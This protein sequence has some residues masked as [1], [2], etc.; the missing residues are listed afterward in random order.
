M[1][2]VEAFKLIK[3]E[4]PEYKL[5]IVGELSWFYEVLMKK[6]ERLK[7]QKDIIFTG[8]LED[9]T[10]CCFYQN[11]SIFVFP[12]LYEGFGIP[13]LEAMAC[14]TPVVASNVCSL[15][16]VVK[17]NGILVNPYDVE[18]IANG[19]YKVLKDNNL[20]QKLIKKGLCYVKDFS[21][22]KSAQKHIEVYEKVGKKQ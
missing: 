9:Q 10:L 21:W 11:A 14:G 7:L 8:Y 16:E 17:D 12:S 20:R 13:V 15:P 4:F 19:I 6:I 3:E 1:R 18:D 5:V 2:L 22:E